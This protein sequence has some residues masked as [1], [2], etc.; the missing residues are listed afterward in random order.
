MSSCSYVVK[1]NDKEQ[2]RQVVFV[3]ESNLDDGIGDGEI[4]IEIQRAK[5]K[6]AKVVAVY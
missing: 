2:Q 3:V 6:T 5:M 4:D 1:W